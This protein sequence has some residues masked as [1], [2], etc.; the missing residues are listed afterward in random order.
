LSNFRCQLSPPIEDF[1]ATVLLQLHTIFK[2]SEHPMGMIYE[3]NSFAWELSQPGCP[4]S[5]K[6]YWQLVKPANMRTVH[7]E[8]S[9]ACHHD[10]SAWISDSCWEL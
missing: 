4:Q 10:F 7:Q 9:R 8:R 6:N 5:E 2:S 3:N 1:L